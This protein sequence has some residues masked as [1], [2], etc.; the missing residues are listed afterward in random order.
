MA[1]HSKQHVS[2][3]GLCWTGARSRKRRWSVGKSQEI[4]AQP[5]D[6]PIPSNGNAVNA[7]NPRSPL[8]YPARTSSGRRRL[9][10]RTGQAM[11]IVVPQVLH[12]HPVPALP[13][14][15]EAS[16]ASPT[17]PLHLHLSASAPCQIPLVRS[18]LERNVAGSSPNEPPS[19]TGRLHTLPPEGT[20]QGAVNSRRLPELIYLRRQRSCRVQR[21]RRC[22]LGTR[23]GK[24]KS[25]AQGVVERWRGWAL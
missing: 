20:H 6:V 15:E 23:S 13:L 11:R 5:A 3:G 7:K 24:S 2:R 21:S 22:G 1:K 17:R 8:H 19:A 14:G 18:A 10:A 12:H 25:R 9:I 4:A 16:A